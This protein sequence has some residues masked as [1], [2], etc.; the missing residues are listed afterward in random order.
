MS[1]ES[2][3]PVQQTE[4]PKRR[5]RLRLDLSRFGGVL[6]LGLIGAGILA[7]GVGWNGAASHIML[8][9]QMPYLVSGLGMG[10]A[11]VIFGAAL[12]VVR[13][14]RE[15]RAALETKL[16]DVI[17]AISRA[18]L[19]GGQLRAPRDLHGLVAAGATS[20]H[21]PSCKLVDGRDE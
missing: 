5:R 12:L 18:G 15:D 3:K 9:Q 13:S 20:Y 16:D 4:A 19:G 14:A 10:L 8:P 21:D 11:L 1:I 17:A 6:A 7:V 2:Y